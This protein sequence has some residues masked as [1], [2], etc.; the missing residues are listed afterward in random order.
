MISKTK[1]KPYLAKLKVRVQEGLVCLSLIRCDGRIVVG[2]VMSVI[3]G[4]A[5]NHRV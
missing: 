1:T 2:A 4:V 5:G 3:L